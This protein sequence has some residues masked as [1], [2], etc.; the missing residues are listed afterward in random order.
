MGQLHKLAL[1]HFQDGGSCALHSP[2]S[3]DDPAMLLFI[4]SVLSGLSAFITFMRLPTSEAVRA[5]RNA[6]PAVR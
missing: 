6:S 1:F 5:E 2:H 3:V 4:L